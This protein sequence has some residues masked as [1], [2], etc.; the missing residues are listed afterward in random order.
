MSNVRGIAF[1]SVLEQVALLRGDEIA[2]MVRAL[3]PAAL[4]AAL[5]DGSL[6]RTGWY[7][8]AD[9]CALWTAILR[10]TGEGEA[11]VHTIG[12]H[13]LKADLTGFHR[14]A[15][16]VLSPGMV[17][18]LGARAFKEYYQG[19]TMET[20]ASRPGYGHVAWKGCTGFDA[21]V[22]TEIR[23]SASMLLE[24]TGAKNI[25]VRL[26]EG[27]QDGDESM[28]IEGSWG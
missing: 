1:H 20:V 2:D 23:G 28:E 21:N 24:L 16:H 25:R 12:R 18:T 4:S 7:P 10:A 5:A 15:I 6:T 26:L 14:V 9:Y 22:W 27:G 19:G 11:L 3:V 17:L 13:T 8:V